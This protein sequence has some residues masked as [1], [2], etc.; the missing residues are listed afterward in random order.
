[1]VF[2]ESGRGERQEEGGCDDGA[3]E[4][5]ECAEHGDERAL[6]VP[7][8]ESEGERERF[9]CTA[10]EQTG[11]RSREPGGEEGERDTGGEERN[12]DNGATSARSFKIPDRV[13]LRAHG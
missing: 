4:D 1:V 3:P 11:G 7:A 2:L 12:A 13:F 10:A 8:F 6:V 5:G 9:D